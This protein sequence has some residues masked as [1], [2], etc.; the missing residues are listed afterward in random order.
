MPKLPGAAI[1]DV[2]GTL[3]D[4][5]ELHYAAWVQLAAALSKPFTRADFVATFGRRN[6]DI[7]RSLFDA[8]A[9]DVH[10]VGGRGRR[11]A[12]GQGR[13]HE[14][15]GGALRRPSCRGQTPVGRGRFGRRVVGRDH[16]R[17]PGTL[18]RSALSNRRR[19]TW[20]SAARRE[21][22]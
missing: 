2:D 22:L 14:M 18:G 15:R 9:G 4:T 21:R 16:G 11:R 7:I 6:P 5:A 20:P 19:E 13:R 3:V 10:R 17:G 1:W 8:N 12:G